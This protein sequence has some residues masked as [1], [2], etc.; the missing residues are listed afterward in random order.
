MHVEFLSH[1]SGKLGREMKLNRYGH[2]G[3]P[4]VVFPSSGGSY[5]EY[6]NFGMIN[7]SRW[8]IENGIVQFFTL[9]NIDGE[10]W[11]ANN[12]SMHDR[13]RAHEAYDQYVIG[14]AIPFIK[15]K[16][17]WFE[18]MGITGCSMGAYHTMNFFLQ[19][20]DVFSTVIALSGIY[21]AHFFG[22]YGNDPLV[23]KNSPSEAIWFQDDGW[24]IDHYRRAKIIVCTGHGPWEQD[25][26][27]SFYQLKKAFQMKNL[28]GSFEEWGH[29][30]AH[31]WE[32]WRLQMPFFL[33]KLFG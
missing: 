21:D 33:N 6:A 5:D 10:S 17:G 1:W 30:V 12:K 22:D 14:E 29:D 26:L 23:F 25:G 32:W 28:G 8:F 13:A 2:G 15:H 4:F 27:D 18:P 16:T 3:M 19:H 9:S 24:F 7:A 20:P 31:D 11:L